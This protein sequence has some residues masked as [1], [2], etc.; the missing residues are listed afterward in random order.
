MYSKRPARKLVHIVALAIAVLAVVPGVALAEGESGGINILIPK[1]AEFI[2]ALIAFIIIWAVLAKL[3]WPMIMGMMDSR[4]KKIQDDIDAAEKVKADMVAEKAAFD[5]QIADANRQ[6][7][8]ILSNARTAAEEERAEIKA[9]AQ[10]EAAEIIAK[11]REAVA[12]ERQAAMSE[13]TDSVADLA[14][15]IAGKI[16]GEKL[17]VAGQR[18]L[19]DKCLSE[20]GSFNAN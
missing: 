2:P 15:D 1:L 3:A 6:A 13:L 14:V 5:A 19:I 4:E 7:E 10:R 20:V 18:Q 9:Q 12:G 8:E 11:A 16:I 17:D